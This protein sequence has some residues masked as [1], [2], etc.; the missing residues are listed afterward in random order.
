MSPRAAASAPVPFYDPEQLRTFLAVAQSLSFTQAAN[1]LGLRQPT[2]SQQIRRLEEAVGRELFVRDTRSVSLT[3]DGESMAGFARSILAAHE[4]A[5]GYFTGSGLSGR[6][7][8]GV[9]DDLALTQIPRILR[10]FRQLYPRI[11]LELMVAQSS[12]LQRRVESNHLE[13]AFVKNLAGPIAP[14]GSLVRRDRLVWAS[15]AGT[16]V[17]ADEPVRLVVYQAPSE[18]RS[19][20]VQALERENR[21]Y[22]ISCTVRGVN[23]VIAAVRAGLGIAVVARTLLPGDFVERPATD[24]LPE[25]GEMDLVL[26]RSARAA[27]EPVEALTRT[28]LAS[29]RPLAVAR[30]S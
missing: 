14:R 18:S 19:V 16:K 3:A 24:G 11:D 28:I 12:V 21:A 9:T 4:Q 2:V 17:A 1:R 29:G 23:G 30:D 5:V 10:E 15:I 6:L 26:L 7:R 22:R 13:L 27:S 20:A 8:L 25:L